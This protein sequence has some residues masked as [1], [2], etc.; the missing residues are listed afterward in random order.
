MEL[1]YVIHYIFIIKHIIYFLYVVYF[2]QDV[3]YG[4]LNIWNK[5]C[6]VQRELPSPIY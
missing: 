2:Q 4:L 3:A 5:K 6:M 1:I